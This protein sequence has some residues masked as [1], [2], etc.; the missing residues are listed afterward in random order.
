MS[1]VWWLMAGLCLLGSPVWGLTLAWNPS[2]GAT[3]YRLAYGRASGVYATVVDTGPATSA[4]VNGLLV[5]ETYYFAASAYNASG[6]SGYSNEVN[7]VIQEVSPID[8]LP[9]EVEI[10]SPEDGAEVRRR[11]QVT[12]MA[13]THDDRGVVQVVITVN[14]Q[15]QCALSLTPAPCPWRVPAPPNRTYRLQ[16]IAY[17]AEGNRGESE[18]VTVTSR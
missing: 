4:S 6:V 11:E 17:D 8:I 3:G 13:A 5:G 9:P 2:L 1:H 7:A 18:V 10:T 16:A 12:I 14:G 15:E